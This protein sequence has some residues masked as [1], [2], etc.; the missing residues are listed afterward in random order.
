[1]PQNGRE[2]ARGMV[3][4]SQREGELA[5]RWVWAASAGF[6]G[7]SKEWVVLTRPSPSITGLEVLQPRLTVYGGSSFEEWMARESMARGP[8]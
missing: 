6:D 5:G 8:V 7:A 3:P 2:S 1:M 4:T